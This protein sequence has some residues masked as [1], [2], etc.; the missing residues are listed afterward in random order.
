MATVDK[1]L[2]KV[3]T[4]HPISSI[5][6]K[7]LALTEDPDCPIDELV[8]LVE[9]DPA[10]TA[11]LLR[12]CNSVYL[13]LPVKVDSVQQ[14]VAL[15]GFRKVFDIVMAQAFSAN[16]LSAQ[17]GYKLEKGDLWQQ[18]VAT[19]MVARSL[20]ERRD[21]YALPAIYTAALLKD[22]G[23]VVLHEYVENQWDKI[24]KCLDTR[25]Y[26]FIDAEKESLGMDHATLGGIIAR[27]WNFSDHMVYMVENH[28][29]SN[30]EARNDPATATLYLADMVAMMVGTCTGVDR[31]AYHLYEDIFKDFFLAKDELK[32]LMLTYDG[33]LAGARRLLE[34]GQSG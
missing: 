15:L 20:A 13:G 8:N 33:Y 32:A 7:I 10:A 2:Q 34:S 5:I 9:Y 24:Q 21:L 3:K 29:L 17:T 4:L 11:N 26:S 12:I 19:A 23:K 6:H 25:G 1:I 16:M 14:A 30:P 31:L 18:S 22:I 27:E 28:H